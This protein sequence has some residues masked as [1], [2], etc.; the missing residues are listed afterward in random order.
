MKQHLTRLRPR[1]ARDAAEKRCLAAAVGTIEADTLTGVQRKIHIAQ[2]C[3]R[4]VALPVSKADALEAENGCIV[5][6]VRH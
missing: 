4:R 2:H 1:Q 5:M 3:A 6:V